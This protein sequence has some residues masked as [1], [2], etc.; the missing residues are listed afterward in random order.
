ML[1][2]NYPN[3]PSFHNL[4][5]LITSLSPEETINAGRS[6]SAY[7][8][9]GDIVAFR[10]I[11]GAGKT[12]FIKGIALGLGITEEVTSPTYTIISEYEVFLTGKTHM[13]AKSIPFYHVDAYRLEG[14]DDFSAIGGDEI[15]FGKGISVIEWSE[16][17]PNFIPPGA[18]KVDI[19]IKQNQKRLIHIYRELP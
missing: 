12:C 3:N 14:N 16:R 10:G 5:V 15:V 2:E 7:L 8:G 19:E 1:V 6:F 18:F 9:E 13:C 11:L 4:P 17:I